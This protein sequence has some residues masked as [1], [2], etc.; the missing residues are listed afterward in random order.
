MI[1]S[2]YTGQLISDA[3]G[4]AGIIDFYSSD[5]PNNGIYCLSWDSFRQ[6]NALTFDFKPDRD[7]SLL[8][9]ND[10]AIDFMVRGN[11]PGNKL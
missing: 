3:S 1:Y 11:H 10:Y 6:Y 9:S 2:D 8:E 4:G 5:L 7:L